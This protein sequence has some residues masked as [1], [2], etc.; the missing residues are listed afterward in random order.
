MK[1]TKSSHGKGKRSAEDWVDIARSFGEKC[2]KIQHDSKLDTEQ[3]LEKQKALSKEMIKEIQDDPHLSDEDKSVMIN[4]I[5][6]YIED[7]SK[8]HDILQA[9]PSTEPSPKKSKK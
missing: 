2:V 4:S 3:K 5:K 6:S 7:W 8:M 9:G 1:G